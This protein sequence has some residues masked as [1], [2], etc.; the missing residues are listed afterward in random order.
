MS[1]A[2]SASQAGVETPGIRCLSDGIQDIRVKASAEI[3]L[4]PDTRPF[5]PGILLLREEKS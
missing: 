2:T 3:G 1:A 4:M 5:E